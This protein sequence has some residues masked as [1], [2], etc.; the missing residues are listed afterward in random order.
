MQLPLSKRYLVVDESQNEEK[1]QERNSVT[2]CV[3]ER[4]ESEGAQS[5][6]KWGRLRLRLPVAQAAGRRWQRQN[7]LDRVLGSLNNESNTEEQATNKSQLK[8]WK[9]HN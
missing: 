9:L 6:A 5:G 1:E 2:V 3:D 8:R 7:R 4:H